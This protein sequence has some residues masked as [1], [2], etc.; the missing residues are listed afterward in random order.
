[1]KLKRVAPSCHALGACW[2]LLCA[3]GPISAAPSIKALF[4]GDNGHHQPAARA[5]SLIPAM[6]KVGV[7]VV[8]TD[9][10]A[11]LNPRKLAGYDCLIIYANHAALTPDQE[12]ALVDYVESGHG[13][14]P[15]HCASACFTK[16]TKYVRLVGGQFDR[17]GSGVFRPEIV[18]ADHPIM[19]GFKS[20]EVWDESYRHRMLSADRTVLMV[21][22][23]GDHEEPW[24]WVR[25][26]G[27]GRV[28]Y[29]ASGHDER[30]WRNPGFLNLLERGIRWAAGG[31]PTDAHAVEDPLA[32][33]V[34]TMTTPA[35]KET[36]PFSYVDAKIAFYPPGE[37]S[38]GGGNWNQMQLPLAPADSIQHV[39]VP[40]GFTVEL[41]AAEPDI[42]K[43]ITMAWDER[44]RLWLAET[45]DYPNS[46]QP[47]GQG[48]DRIRICEDTNGDG[49]ADKFTVFAERL[50]IP[51]S[52][53]F[54]RGGVIVHQA[55]Q[56]LFL[57]DTNGDDRADVRRVLFQGWSTGD[58]HAGPSNLQYG[59]DNWLWGTQGYAGFD[60]TVG[61]EHLNFR[62]GFYRFKP[63]GSRLEFIRST[64]N[65]T[66][67]L[68]FSEEGLVFGSTANRNPSVYM[69]IANRYYEAVRGWSPTVPAGIADTYL[70]HAPTEK[71][72]QVDHHG[73]YTAAAGHALYT[74]RAYP[75]PYWNRT[76]FVAEPTGHLLGVFVLGREG[77][78]F[79]ST[80]PFNLVAS[81]DEWFAPIMAEVGPDG[82]V[83]LIDWYNYIVQHNPTPAG[84]TTGKGNAYETDLRDQRHGRIYR[85]VYRDSKNS[86]PMNLHA[87]PPEKL[88]AT[89]RH[90]NMLWRKHAQRLLVERGKHDVVAPLAA[91]ARASQPDEIGLDVGAIHALWTLEGLGALDGSQ[92]EASAAVLGALKHV[93][94]GVRRNALQVLPR[95]EI[96]LQALLDSGVLAN[97]D[98]QVRLAALLAL[99]EMPASDAAGNAIAGEL[100]KPENLNDRW[101]PD[102]ATSAAAR[103]DLAFLQALA[104]QA[105]PLPERAREVAGIVASHYTRGRPVETV[106]L[107]LA[108]LSQ[109]D[110]TVVEPV[111]AGLLQGWPK[112]AAATID[113]PAEEALAAMLKKLDSG[114]QAQLLNLASKLGSQGLR[115]YADEIAARLLATAGDL[116]TS[117]EARTAAARQLVSFR[118]DAP[119]VADHLLALV[120]PR[121]SSPLATG[122]I[123]SLGASRSPHVGQALVA[124]LAGLTPAARAAAVRVLMSRTDW[125]AELLGAIDQGQL[126]LSDLSLDQKQAL[127]SYP[128]KILARRAQELL[129]RGGA[130]PSADR[131]KVLNDLV[132]LT[133]QTGDAARG[134]LTFTKACAKCHMHGGE[135]NK[136]GP[137]LTGMAV[138]PKAELL[139]HILDPSR[140]VEGNYR[141]Y[142]VVTDDG[143]VMTGLLAGES[144]TSI[145]LIDA[146]AK[147]HA[148]Q[149]DNIEQLSMSTKSIMPEGFEKQLQPAEL[150]D[151]LE[152]LTAK[153]KFVP[154]PLEKLATVVTTKSMFHPGE[155]GPDRLVFDDWGPKTVYGVPFQLT[156]PRG[157]TLPNA[158][159]FYG[160]SGTLPPRMPTAVRVPCNSRVKALHLLSGV[161]GWG[162]PASPKNTVSLIVRLHY[163]NG[164]SEDHAL[165]NGEEFADY[166]REVDVPRSKL[167]F[168]L[169]GRQ[170][171]YLAISPLRSEIVS[172]I[173][174]VKGPDKTAPIIMAATIETQ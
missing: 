84:F 129:K 116:K 74:A 46:I 109:A 67:G 33:D 166:I 72:R 147:R 102:A 108:S 133:R 118:G 11:D 87:A 93:S 14:V 104:I 37:K 156:D 114:G 25:T 22:R 174:F 165:R 54:A 66:W 29:T 16:S 12:S 157:G 85:I 59:L 139:M 91:L 92:R 130:L 142:T 150:V 52:I 154:L 88:L 2:L 98:A 5:A 127:A 48:N 3:A 71:I 132:S 101:I 100:L 61:G 112:G 36:K 126:Q 24:T 81:D 125:V 169:R 171:R 162:Y 123:E 64:N 1:M 119:E 137:D 80:N 152:F 117:D 148:V 164:E 28:F 151:L 95:S 17:H 138:H 13:L 57:A 69:P 10:L 65:N 86:E 34:P 27:R 30:C 83:W 40:Q 73:G 35:R 99:A 6:Q 63:D 94:A 167:A 131:Q 96:S 68:G 56:T 77:S 38:R 173:E 136:I 51:T 155:N 78:D 26:Q 50:S 149:R 106:R 9:Q 55:P 115:K 43:P 89:L 107:L 53:A 20:Y 32:F 122:L 60:G 21:Y 134:K 79:R 120:T 159:L 172:D 146:E 8:Y 19:Q 97:A 75:K 158:I 62:Q 82:Q 18:A 145:E 103:H 45:V 105:T 110:N 42:G 70:F 128:E 41:F 113:A 160:P 31:N 121:T 90:P 161:S 170:L 7:D 44:G 143:L 4:L 124:G 141:A 140:S 168:K 58:T 39:S 111:V 76:A 49:R 23:E 163:A 135:G 153:G 144:K 47:E 15:I